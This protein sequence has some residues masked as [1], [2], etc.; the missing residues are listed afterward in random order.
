V[1]Q[2]RLAKD[3]EIPTPHKKE[4]VVFTAFFQR[5]FG[6]PSCDFL[7]RLFHH[8]QIELIHLNPNSISDHHLCKY[9]PSADKRKVIGGVGIQS[10][11]RRNFLDLLMT[12]FLKG[13]HKSWFYCENHEPSLP[14]FVGNLPEY[15]GTWVEELTASEMSLVS[16]LAGRI[17][18]IKDLDLTG[19]SVA[20]N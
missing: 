15:D 7:H 17:N 9:Q 18:E 1:I 3:E 5:R 20:T 13:W 8:Y 10:R 4:I 2:W 19:V 16:A 14:P 12:T 6:F 11:P